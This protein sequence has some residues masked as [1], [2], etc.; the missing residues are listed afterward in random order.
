MVHVATRSIPLHVMDDFLQALMTQHWLEAEEN[1]EIHD[2]LRLNAVVLI[3]DPN[4][5]ITHSTSGSQPGCQTHVLDWNALD[6]PLHKLRRS[7]LRNNDGYRHL[8]FPRD[9]HG[10]VW[11]PSVHALHFP[12]RCHRYLHIRWVARESGGPK[13][14]SMGAITVIRTALESL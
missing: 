14:I 4:A 11:P 3:I 12:P 7:R 6:L 5:R 13:W 2:R 8:D 9:S 1:H 10:G